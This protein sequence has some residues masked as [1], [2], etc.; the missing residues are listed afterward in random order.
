MFIL[1]LGY[2]PLNLLF[3]SVDNNHKVAKEEIIKLYKV[4]LHRT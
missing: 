2:S 1:Y 3:D 4:N